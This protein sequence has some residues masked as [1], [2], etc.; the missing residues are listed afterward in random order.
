MYYGQEDKLMIFER[1]KCRFTSN[2]VL[3]DDDLF[4]VTGTMDNSHKP[5]VRVIIKPKRWENLA[6]KLKK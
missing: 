2:E 3:L 4:E 1:V 6:S 5:E